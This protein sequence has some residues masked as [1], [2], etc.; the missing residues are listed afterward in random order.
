MTRA[1][2][3][4]VLEYQLMRH[5]QRWRCTPRAAHAE[6]RGYEIIQAE[7]LKPLLE[8]LETVCHV[9]GIDGKGC[10]P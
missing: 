5:E 3:R 8:R 1:D 2:A 4:K 9:C 10:K 7:K 6:M